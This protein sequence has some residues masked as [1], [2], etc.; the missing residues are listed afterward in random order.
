MCSIEEANQIG[1]IHNII[2]IVIRCSM[3]PSDMHYT[4][5]HNQV[6]CQYLCEFRLNM[7]QLLLAISTKMK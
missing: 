2:W 7:G 5:E 6:G 1:L 3:G 4:F